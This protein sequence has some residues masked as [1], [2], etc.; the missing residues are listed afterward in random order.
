M[1]FSISS[2]ETDR[3]SPILSKPYPASSRGNS[4]AGRRATEKRSRTVLLYWTR[5]SLR[6]VTCVGSGGSCGRSSDASIHAISR[7][8]S[9]LAGDGDPGGGILPLLTL[10]STFSQTDLELPGC[11]R[12]RFAVFTL[13]LWHVR[14]FFAR[15]GRT[16]SRN[17]D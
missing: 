9:A 15:K 11:S 4:P 12:L 1:Y 16:L 6:K 5:F 13:S 7:A 3:T 10:S 17:S 2:G 8:T 14:Q